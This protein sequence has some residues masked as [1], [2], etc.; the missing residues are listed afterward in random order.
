M[1]LPL[2][3]NTTYAVGTE[4]K[5]ADLND[6]QDQIID[7]HTY[8]VEDKVDH[9]LAVEGPLVNGNFTFAPS[10]W[11]ATAAHNH[12]IPLPLRPGDVLQSID[13]LIDRAAAVSMNLVVFNAPNTGGDTLIGGTWSDVSVNP[14]VGSP[15]I[16]TLNGTDYTVLDEK[17]Y[18][19]ITAGQSGDKVYKAIVNYSTPA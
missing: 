3:R 16:Y 19:I 7:L 5:S 2:T 11:T 15:Q 14:T 18:L 10:I 12:M 1:A 13:V 6:I 4:V 9:V 8:R 17:L